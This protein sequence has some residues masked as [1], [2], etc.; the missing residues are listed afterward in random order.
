MGC[1]KLTYHLNAEPRLRCVYN[2]ADVA[3]RTGSEAWKIYYIHRDYLGS[4]CAI[5]NTPNGND[6]VVA[7]EKR[8]YDAWGRLRKPTTLQPYGPG[9]QPTLFLNRGYTS[10][11]HLPEFGLINCNARLYDP[12]I[13]RFLSPDPFVQAPEFSQSYNRYSYCLNNPLIYVD[14]DGEFWHLVIGAV[15]GGISIWAMNGFEFS[16]K[17]LG[18]FGVGALAGALGA[19]VGA[20]VSSAMTVSGSV[21]GGFAAGFWGTTAATTATS[22]FLTGA[23]IGGAAGFSSGFVTGLGNGL[24][25]GK[26]FGQALWNGTTTGFWGGVAGGVLGG[27]AGGIDAM[28]DGRRFF[29]GSTV[30]DYRLRD[31]NI[32]FIPQNA[33]Y[34]CGPASAEAVTNG[35]LQ[36]NNVRNHFGGDPNKKGIDD[37]KVMQ[38]IQSKT[39]RNVVPGKG[40]VE[41]IYNAM[42][43]NGNV[44]LSLK[45][46]PGHMVVANS[47][48]QTTITK[49]NGRVI[50]RL[51]LEVM[52]P[53]RG[54]YIRQSISNN[55]KFFTIF[56]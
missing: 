14:E 15:I 7:I 38:H 30:N 29:D 24:L 9:E 12:I 6:P 47:V 46:D 48:W 5:T 43:K 54:Q 56:F 13:G 19:G 3:I 25:D 20:G 35:Q 8:S 36:Q 17:G 53:A 27:L 33:D 32:Q 49:P 42:T 44:V 51:F 11:E 50:Q 21:S 41:A 1:P 52:D 10:H 37:L 22:S 16:W 26:N 31:H 28:R 40:D 4:I 45:G 34:N 39:G 23:A 55:Q 2:A 18:Y